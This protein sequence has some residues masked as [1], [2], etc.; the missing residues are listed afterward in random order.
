MGA[1]CHIAVA[2]IGQF[3]QRERWIASCSHVELPFQGAKVATIDE[4]D[5]RHGSNALWESFDTALAVIISSITVL[6]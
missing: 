3:Y 4:I 6:D 1:A 2:A 5:S